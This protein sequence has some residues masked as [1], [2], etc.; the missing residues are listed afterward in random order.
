MT[1]NLRAV[2]LLWVFSEALFTLSGVPGN[3]QGT[4]VGIH[5]HEDFCSR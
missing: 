1:V 5:P 4:L 3:M 2:K